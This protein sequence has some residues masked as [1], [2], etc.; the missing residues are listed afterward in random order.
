MAVEAPKGEFAIYLI[1]DGKATSPTAVHPCAGLSA[2]A[3][4]GSPQPRPHAGGHHR[5]PRLA[6]HRLRGDRPVNA[7]SSASQHAENSTDITAQFLVCVG[8]IH[9]LGYGAA[10]LRTVRARRRQCLRDG[11]GSR[12]FATIG[13]GRCGRSI[14]SCSATSERRVSS[15][16]GSFVYTDGI[17][18]VITKSSQLCS[19]SPDAIVELRQCPRCEDALILDNPVILVEVV[20]P[21][22]EERDVHAKLHDYFAI[23]S[24]AHYLIVYDDRRFVVHPSHATEAGANRQDRSPSSFAREKSILFS[25]PGISISVSARWIFR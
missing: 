19:R 9:R 20:S 5:H 7:D 23:G 15:I 17:T 10:R 25:P 11:T 4:D 13:L 6:R 24:V 16:A 2:P 21:S 12:A 18:G 22:S 1:A 8:R 3:G 14:C